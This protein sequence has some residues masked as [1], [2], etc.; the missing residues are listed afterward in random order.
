MSFE[1]FIARRIYS[2]KTDDGERFSR[3][4]VRV[5]M[6][7]VAIGLAV[8]IVSLAVV[9]GFKREIKSKVVGFG[10]NIQV[11]S[12]TQNQKYE[13]LPINTDAAVVNK[14]RNR[15]KCQSHTADSHSF[16]YA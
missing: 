7:G 15:G 11:I 13:I 10:G 14:V 16:G 1:R 12:L 9:L 4:A 5:A 3:P 6:L 2:D 8:M